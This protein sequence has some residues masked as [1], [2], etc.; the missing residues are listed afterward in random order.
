MS[1][2]VELRLHTLA[3]YVVHRVA[4]VPLTMTVHALTTELVGTSF[5]GMTD[6]KSF[7]E[8]YIISNWTREEAVS[9]D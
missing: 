5:S 4:H 7:G 3:R 8:F 9:L 1:V 2:N 6:F